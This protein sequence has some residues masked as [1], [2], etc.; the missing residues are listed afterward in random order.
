MS[1]W[2]NI[3]YNLCMC[4][5]NVYTCVCIVCFIKRYLQIHTI[6]Q[7]NNIAVDC[8]PLPH[9]ENGGVNTSSGTTFQKVSHYSCYVGYTLSGA[10]TRVCSENGQWIPDA[11][12]CPSEYAYNMS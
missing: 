6:H 2:H 9:P 7:Y 11:P 10:M 1:Q 4:K 8:D 5:L 3:M 12:Y